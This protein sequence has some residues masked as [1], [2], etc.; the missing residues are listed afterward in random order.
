VATPE[1]APLLV[2]TLS[3]VVNL[4][5]LNV[6]LTGGAAVVGVALVVFYIWRWRKP[7]L[8]KPLEPVKPPLPV[9][10]DRVADALERIAASL[11]NSGGGGDLA[12]RAEALATQFD[13]LAEMG[14]SAGLPPREVAKAIRESILQ[15]TKT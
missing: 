10:R 11:N 2:N 9:G 5:D 15:A 4:L 14:V 7:K 1:A 3:Y 6:L 12:S 13:K 8:L